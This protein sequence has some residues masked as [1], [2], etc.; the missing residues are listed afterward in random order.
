M[1][2]CHLPSSCLLILAGWLMGVSVVLLPTPSMGDETKSDLLRPAW[3]AME[4]A[5]TFER[6]HAW[7][8]AVALLQEAR[9]HLAKVVGEDHP[10][11][12]AVVLRSGR[13]DMRR[14]Q[15]AMARERYALAKNLVK[16][17]AL[18][19]SLFM[20]ET[21]QSLGEASSQSAPSPV[22]P[23]TNPIPTELREQAAMIHAARFDTPHPGKG[24]ALLWAGDVAKEEGRADAAI[25]NYTQAL[26]IFMKSAGP[27][28]A[29]R[30]E[31]M[32]KLARLHEAREVFEPAAE[33]QKGALAMTET[34]WGSDHP[35]TVPILQSLATNLLAQKKSRQGQPY[36][37]RLLTMTRTIWGVAHLKTLQASLLMADY[38]LADLDLERAS[39]IL[40]GLETLLD[41]PVMPHRQELSL[42]M[43][44][45][46]HIERLRNQ[47]EAA[48]QLHQR[49]R[50]LQTQQPEP[51][52]PTRDLTPVVEGE[53]LIPPPSPSR[54]RPTEQKNPP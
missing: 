54:N 51:P 45:L 19:D 40:H 38:L 7:D 33:L 20:A 52:P 49:A 13:I 1:R 42:V 24:E 43:E 12:L 47:T 2:P 16:H 31:L 8:Q 28:H 46:A 11:F 39:Q 3:E 37:A 6:R 36:V 30:V 41:T 32:L 23:P 22:Y 21:L 50:A 4:S 9:N 10:L 44:R 53:A 5:A 15:Y 17:H 34:M 26:H 14:G 48:G 18:A 35:A 29:K 27:F 25:R